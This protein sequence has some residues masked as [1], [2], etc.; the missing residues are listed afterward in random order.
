MTNSAIPSQKLSIRENF[1]SAYSVLFRNIGVFFGLGSAFVVLMGVCGTWSWLI[2]RLRAFPAIARHSGSERL[3]RLVES[4]TEW[5]VF[6]SILFLGIAWVVLRLCQITYEQLC[7][8]HG[9]LEGA[10]LASV[11]T[12][13]ESLLKRMRS[14]IALTLLVALLMCVP[15]VVALLRILHADVD[16]VGLAAYGQVPFISVLL[17]GLVLP[18]MI[19]IIPVAAIEDL[20]LW[21]SVRRSVT[22]TKGT[23]VRIIGLYYAYMY[24]WALLLVIP[25]SSLIVL[26]DIGRFAD[27]LAIEDSALAVS[28]LLWCAILFPTFV[29]NVVSYYFLRVR[30]QRGASA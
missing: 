25:I 20:G 27:W 18:R 4:A 9:Q 22:L 30:E 13:D 16:T 29:L 17:A 5:M 21:D 8:K 11:R 2:W 6:T 3:L 15:Y 24:S 1:R 23:W 10:H 19:A 28:A 14:I 7:D 12:S 26:V